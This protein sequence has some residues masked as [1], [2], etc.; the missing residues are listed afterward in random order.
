MRSRIAVA[1]LAALCALGIAATGCRAVPIEQVEGGAAVKSETRS[2]ER[3]TAERVSVYLEMGAGELSLAGGAA[4][5]LEGDFEYAPSR[6]EPV[7]DEEVSGNAN[8]IRIGQPG[9]DGM[10]PLGTWKNVWDIAL[11]DGI[12]TDLAV[13][14][15]AGKS[16]LELG[17][18][19]L[20]AVQVATG[21]GDTVLDLTTTETS[22]SAEASASAG[23]ATP[24]SVECGAG[25]LRVA[26]SRSLGVRI[27]DVAEGIGDF[28]ADGF[29]RDGDDYVT[30]AWL[31]GQRDYDFDIKYGVGD[32]KVE[33]ID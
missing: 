20:V 29:V 4:D 30:Q 12:P 21:A 22:G 10:A 6:L 8:E 3:G 13:T 7:V 31:D 14:L 18:L 26:V 23:R 17:T 27:A 32:V 25:T 15:G 19:D 28:R 9:A 1:A 24:V 16:T 2:V 5:L 11:A 33:V